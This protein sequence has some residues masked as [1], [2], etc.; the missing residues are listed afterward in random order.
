MSS[1]AQTVCRNIINK[2]ICNYEKI[3]GEKC[4]FFHPK[5]C[6]KF[7]KD[8]N[9]K[10]GNECR[11]IH[12][13]ELIHPNEPT[14]S[15]EISHP[16]KSYPI[17]KHSRKISHSRE[18]HPKMKSSS[19]DDEI[20]VVPDMMVKRIDDYY[21]FLS[22]QNKILLS[23]NKELYDENRIVS[24][25]NIYIKDE[26]KKLLEIIKSNISDISS[27]ETTLLQSFSIL[28]TLSK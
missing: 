26:L 14:H 13:K 6:F 12:P 10:Y 11:Y 19:Y 17:E 5:V 25:E 24:I 3:N 21:Q 16:I 27:H 28:E 20:V 8:R 1:A 4:I 2:G 15:R 9:C 7:L 18:I 22:E 23:E